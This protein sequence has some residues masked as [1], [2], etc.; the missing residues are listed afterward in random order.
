MGRKKKIIPLDLQAIFRESYDSAV[1]D[2]KSAIQLFEK[3]KITI[4]KI[5]LDSKNQCGFQ[6]M[7]SIVTAA[8]K[9]LERSSDSNKQLIK[10]AEILQNAENCRSSA[11]AVTAE[12][13]DAMMK[14]IENE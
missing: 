3:I 8:A 10:I 13:F 4:E 6:E 2:K 14:D 5:L 1:V 7:A 12:E 9:I 11:G